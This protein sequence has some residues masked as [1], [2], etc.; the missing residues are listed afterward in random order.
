[1]EAK[2]LSSIYSGQ[3]FNLLIKLFGGMDGVLPYNPLH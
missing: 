1:M 3:D 2:K